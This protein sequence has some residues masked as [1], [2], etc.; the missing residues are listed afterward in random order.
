M[1]TILGGALGIC[2]AAALLRRE[3]GVAGT[4]FLFAGAVLGAG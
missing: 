3:W 4:L 1:S 2:S